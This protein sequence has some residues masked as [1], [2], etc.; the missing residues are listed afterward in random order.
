MKTDPLPPADTRIM[1]IVH[2]ALRRDLARAGQVLRAAPEPGRTQ[3]VALADHLVWMMHFLHLH[4]RGE[5]AG[6]WPLVRELNPAA[7]ALLDVMNTDHA[8]IGPEIERVTAAATEY[9]AD[10]AARE[11]LSISLADLGGVLLPHLQREESEMMP[12]VTRTLTSRQWDEVEQRVFIASK[13]KRELG[14]EAH[15]IID[16]VDREDYDVAVGKVDPATRFMLLHA[17][18]RSYRQ[19]CAARWGAELDVGPRLGAPPRTEGSVEMWI[20]APAQQLYDTVADVTRIGERSPECRSC[21]WLPGRPSGTVEA[22]FRGRNRAHHMRWSRVCEVTAADPGEKFGFRTLSDR[23]NPL[24]H[25]ST[26]WTYTFEADGD[27]TRVIHSYRI[28]VLPYRP[29]FWLYARLQPQHRDMRPQMRQNLEA[30]RQQSHARR[31]R[32]G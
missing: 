24:Y 8:R 15:W 29:L 6:L 2:N 12:V 17:F 20:D 31:S 7:G 1:R 3:R 13:T 5:D 16:G 23:R 25:D 14:I 19:A 30:L 21:A 4:H 10:P 32:Y 27:R 26:T 22:R 9:R 18:E 28:D 11:E